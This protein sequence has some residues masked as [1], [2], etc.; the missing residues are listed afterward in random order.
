MRSRLAILLA[1]T[2]LV[3]GVPVALGGSSHTAANSQTFPDSIGEDASAPDITSIVV[4]ND[5]AGLI[6]FQINV[7]NRPALTPDAAAD[8][9]RTEAR[10]GRLDGE[11]VECVLAAATGG[12]RRRAE[13]PGGLTSREVEV[14]RLL[15][16]GLTNAEL[17]QRLYISQKTVD[18]HV[19]A[20]LSKL[21]VA[22]RRVATRAARELGLLD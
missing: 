15:D 3:V 8:E 6:T 22:N 5:D 12:R 9:L 20:I 7:S 11:A 1:L 19:S 10:S 13:H 14:L 16:E 17:A 18:H 2:A 4:S 21:Q